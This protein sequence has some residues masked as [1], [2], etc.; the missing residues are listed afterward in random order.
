MREKDVRRFDRWAA[1]YDESPLQ[2]IFFGRVHAAVLDIVAGLNLE[3]PCLLDIGCGT[4]ALLRKAA[5]RFP[6]S[7]LHGVDPAPEMVRMAREGMPAGSHLDFVQGAAQD[8]PFSD[9]RFDVVLSTV[10]FHHWGDQAQGLREVARVLA[11]GGFFILADMFAISLGRLIYVL[12]GS[13]DRFHAKKE[14]EDLM[15]QA[16][17]EVLSWQVAYPVGPCA[18]AW[19]ITTRKASPGKTGETGKA[20]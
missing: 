17:L 18:I 7:E 20:E 12:A 2:Q 5:G 6:Q 4:G 1:N 10:S 11:P 3:R 13:R 14:I 16:G 15:R 8:L 19:A 9:A